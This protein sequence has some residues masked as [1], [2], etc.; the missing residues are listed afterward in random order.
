MPFSE[1]APTGWA[2]VAIAILAV[3]VHAGPAR[4]GSD[5]DGDTTT[6]A[7]P[8]AHVEEPSD[9]DVA[10]VAGVPDVPLYAECTGFTIFDRPEPRGFDSGVYDW[11]FDEAEPGHIVQDVVVGPGEE[12]VFGGK[13]SYGHLGKDLE[14]ERVRAFVHECLDWTE[15]GSAQTDA[16]GRSRISLDTSTLPANAGLFRVVHVVDGDASL[17]TSNLFVLPER[18]KVVVFD[19]DGTLTESNADLISQVT[20]PTTE[21]RVV[22]DAAELTHLWHDRGYHIA[23]LT[24]RPF[25]LANETRRWLAEH[26]FAPGSL[27]TT[28]RHRDSLPHQSAVG[29]YKIDYLESF[30]ERG[31]EIVAAYG[32]SSTDIAAYRAVGIPEHR[33]FIRGPLGGDEETEHVG[34]SYADHCMWVEGIEMCDQPWIDLKTR[35]SGER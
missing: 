23:Y 35:E 20:D 29:D 26:G 30:G 11:L 13:F 28:D 15:F 12:A 31:L 19:I 33:I 27:R 4:A 16:D 5:S 22:D 2:V 14:D 7:A 24:G 18:T 6:A 3:T 10:A 9:D 34:G 1:R 25:W 8:E 17:A 32:N 21:P